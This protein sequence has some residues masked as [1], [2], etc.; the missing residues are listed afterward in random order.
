ML[1]T[2]SF[3]LRHYFYHSFNA[4]IALLILVRYESGIGKGQLQDIS[5][6]REQNNFALM[7][8]QILIFYDPMCS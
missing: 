8:I 6:Q 3:I 2:V 5:Q 7:R 1:I 4:K